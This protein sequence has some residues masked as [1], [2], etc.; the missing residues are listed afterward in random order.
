MESMKVEIKEFINDN[1]DL[2]EKKLLSEAK[3]VATK[4]TEILQ[5]VNINLLSNAEKLVGYIIEDDK[6]NLIAF[7]KIEGEA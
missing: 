6:V 4:I 2:F 5:K 1:R 7:A 3:N